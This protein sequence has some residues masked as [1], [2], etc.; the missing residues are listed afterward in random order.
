MVTEVLLFIFMILGLIMYI[1]FKRQFGFWQR[2]KIAFLPPS[3]PMG[4]IS[5]ILKSKVHFGYIIQNIYNHMKYSG[6]YCGIFFS[7]NPVLLVLTPEFAKTVLVRDFSY[8]EDRGVYS[9]ESIDPLGANMFFLEGERWKR[10][11]SKLSP[12]FSSGKL[13]TMFH[14]ISDVGQKFVSHLKPF[15]ELSQDIEVYDLFARYTTDCISSCAFGFDANSLKDPKTDFVK[16][17]KKVLHFPKL[18]ALKI[19]FAMGFRD[20][21]KSL[22]IRFNDEDVQNFFLKMVHDTIDYRNRTGFTRKD[23]VQQLMDLMN[24][25]VDESDKITFNE[26][27]AQIFGFY[28]AG[29]DSSST[30]LAFTLHFLAYHLNVQEKGRKCIAS[31]LE[32]HN[33][34]WSYDLIMD[35]PYIDAIIDESLRINPPVPTLHRI[36]TKDYTLPNGAS[37]ET[38]T[39]VVI[40]SLAFQRDPDIFPDPLKFDP[41]RFCKKSKNFHPFSSLPFGGGPRYCLGMRL[42]LLQIKLAIA[43]MIH[44]FDIFPSE[45]SV[46]PIKID[47]ATLIHA[48]DGQKNINFFDYL[49]FIDI[50]MSKLVHRDIS[51]FLRS[52]RNFLLGR[53]HTNALR[54]EDDIAARTQPPPTLPDGPSHRFSANYYLSRD[55]RREV[56]NPNVISAQKLIPDGVKRTK[57][58]TPGTIYKWDEH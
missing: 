36:V 41:E 45:N 24:D 40:P 16:M 34:E 21:A 6:D 51:P 54:F 44:N 42:G 20:K 23:F 1:D 26:V 28:F 13:K 52:V 22:G 46:Y 9:N 32:K 30:T 38:G 8:F 17:G 48:P 53:K 14:T 47:P 55:P 57:L 7:R 12:S 3:F 27:A 37:L 43:L 4:N 10:I 5:E 58:P 39:L 11:R 31:A 29:F 25:N 33:N 35:M 15:A 18:K 50:D 49:N 2:K 56:T 19:F